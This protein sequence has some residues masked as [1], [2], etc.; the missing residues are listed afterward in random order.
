MWSIVLGKSCV[1]T[2]ETTEIHNMS[3]FLDEIQD[4]ADRAPGAGRTTRRRSGN[5]R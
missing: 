5:W 1:R 4:V 3:S 2:G